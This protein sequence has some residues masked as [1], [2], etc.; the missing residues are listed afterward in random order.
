[1]D[2]LN[3]I[4]DEHGDGIEPF[5]QLYKDM[6]EQGLN[7]EDIVNTVRYGKDLPI[8]D[9]KSK[10]RNTDII[11]IENRK[12]TLLFEIQDLE[13][14]VSFKECDLYYGPSLGTEKK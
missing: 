7:T 3:E 11:E 6:N 5:I 4:Y 9:L 10:K 1:M 14:T 12:Q 13:D 2:E 8:L